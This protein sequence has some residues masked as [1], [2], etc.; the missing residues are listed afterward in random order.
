MPRYLPVV[1]APQRS[2][3]LP[4]PLPKI[5]RSRPLRRYG[6]FCIRLALSIMCALLAS[7]T[8]GS[9][10]AYDQ[11]IVKGNLPDLTHLIETH[12]P[13]AVTTFNG[14]DL[15]T[16]EQGK[17]QAVSVKVGQVYKQLTTLLPEGA[18]IRAIETAVIAAEDRDFYEHNGVSFSALCKAVYQLPKT[19]RMRGASTITMQLGKQ[20]L[21]NE[22]SLKRKLREWYLAVKL[23]HDLTKRYGS[24]LAAKKAILRAYLN[25]AYVGHGRYG[26][27]E[28]A[29]YYFA[30]SASSLNLKQAAVLAAIVKGA[31][32]YT[33]LEGK[34]ADIAASRRALEA[35]TTYVL[36]QLQRA[37]QITPSEFAELQALPIIFTIP[38][39]EPGVC[40]EFVK[41]V[42][43]ELES[44]YGQ[45][46][47]YTPLEVTT[48]CNIP[49]QRAA[50]R[51]F[52]EHLSAIDA[53]NGN[54]PRPQ[55]TLTIIEQKTGR[56]L[57]L[58]GGDKYQPGHLVR[59]FDANRPPGSAA[60]IL[61][62]LA[63]LRLG[64]L[65]SDAFRDSL[66]TIP[67]LEPGGKPWRPDNA[68]NRSNEWKTLREA[69]AL[70][71]N[72]VFAQ[73]M[74]DIGVQTKNR[75][76]GIE[77]MQ[78][79]ARDLNLPT[80]IGR[81]YSS[82]LGTFTMR[83]ID[84]ASTVSTIARN[85]SYIE[86]HLFTALR[87]TVHTEAPWIY[88][89]I[90]S[91]PALDPRL[92]YLLVSLM[93]SVVTSGTGIRA[94]SL[95]FETIAKTGT[96]QENKDAHFCGASTGYTVCIWIGYD[97]PQNLGIDRRTGREIQ[98]A[99]NAPLFVELMKLLHGRKQPEAFV[100]P[101]GLAHY[102]TALESSLNPIARP[103]CATAT[104]DPPL[105][106]NELYLPEFIPDGCEPVAGVTLK[107]KLR[108]Q[109]SLVSETSPPS[110]P[111]QESSTPR[112]PVLPPVATTAADQ[113]P[114]EESAHSET[115]DDTGR[116]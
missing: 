106:K 40:D 67:P 28:A 52:E 27:E 79:V 70:S 38:R 24:K 93:R 75:Y 18:D 101:A 87:E 31:E 50:R 107:P 58:I 10:I 19:R 53:A 73:L 90:Q 85:G 66:S 21:G 109:A 34:P 49:L 25:Q 80:V 41:I 42:N 102:P 78:A 61:L 115:S 51:L 9:Y 89:D 82:A 62:L 64:Y 6:R 65:P 96:S 46:R 72:T 108:G 59:A 39:Y 111:S 60:K 86:P 8:I 4:P 110:I 26:F 76:A 13:D 37:R 23:E 103:R 56:I 95:K 98:G 114:S 14:S 57:A 20:Y 81:H 47:K 69:F 74:Y 15:I 112:L 16:D 104:D 11:W 36:K 105:I 92:S 68:H 63:A 44:L 30:Q 12:K 77:G 88:R 17:T 5:V 2:N 22:R 33:V 43:Q 54:L 83:P 7:L 45:G 55:G 35:R 113:A 97:Q 32:N 94:N 84:L 29:R 3:R 116:Y 100:E 99:S 91:E 1:R 71:L 48:T